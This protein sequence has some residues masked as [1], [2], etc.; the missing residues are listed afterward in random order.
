MIEFQQFFLIIL[1]STLTILI[2]IFSIFVFRILQELRETIRKMNSILD[3]VGTISHSV[4][5]P[6]ANISNM[7][8]GLKGGMKIFEMVGN[9]IG[10]KSAEDAE[11]EAEEED[12]DD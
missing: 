7:M 8:E 4:A 3:D 11:V 9:I 1:I 12:D 6:V 2:V 5:Q 10:K